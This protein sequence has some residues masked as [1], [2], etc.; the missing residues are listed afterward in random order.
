M[1]TKEKKAKWERVS[2]EVIKYYS[3]GDYD[4]ALCVLNEII[5]ECPG[6]LDAWIHRG[7]VWNQKKEYEKAI[8]D[9][10]V[11]IRSLR[12]PKLEID[13]D[14]ILIIGY[15]YGLMSSA[16]M[17]MEDYNN[18][19]FY[20]IL[21]IE[22]KPSDNLQAWANN[23]F[24]WCRLGNFENSVKN[25]GECLKIKSDDPKFWF[26]R[27][28]SLA[29]LKQYNDALFNVGEAIKLSPKDS[30]YHCMK[31]QILSSKGMIDN[32][33]DVATFSI[34]IEPSRKA[35][36]IRGQN[37]LHKKEYR[38]ALKDFK[39]S[40]D[41]DDDCKKDEAIAWSGLGT[42]LS[43]LKRYS[44]SLDAFSN[45][46]HIEPNLVIAWANRGSTYATMGNYELAESDLKKALK[47]DPNNANANYN[48]GMMEEKRDNMK[49]KWWKRWKWFWIK[50]G[51]M[52]F[53]AGNQD[54]S[55]QLIRTGD[56]VLNKFS[57]VG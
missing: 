19:L 10:K 12:Q 31:S 13:S 25:Y 7:S 2:E 24:A 56:V 18:G 9:Y 17:N 45:A 3:D 6:Y 36:N 38:I 48:L 11:V 39:K 35:Y 53:Y 43:H 34:S 22:L 42:S 41:I 8:S 47:L 14:P 29:D 49:E 44:E 52:E 37:W 26:N 23:A 40:I 20:S 27:A 5:E 57:I 50:N 1:I 21:S 55:N 16:Y 33:I 30:L 51:N 28:C 46:I 54:F 15:V 4:S 32:S